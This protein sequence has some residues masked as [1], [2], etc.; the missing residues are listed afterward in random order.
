MLA[1]SLE[2]KHARSY[3]GCPGVP[4]NPGVS[5]C[6]YSFLYHNGTFSTV[7]F[8]PT[9]VQFIA[10]PQPAG[11][12]SVVVCPCPN[13]YHSTESVL[14]GPQSSLSRPPNRQ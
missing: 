11:S 6:L 9:H 5:S 7:C 13:V 2:S 14:D 4:N 12:P 10:S 1:S 8:I 3:V